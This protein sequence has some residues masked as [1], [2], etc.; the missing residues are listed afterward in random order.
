MAGHNIIFILIGIFLAYRIF[1][2]VQR[3]FGWQQLSL[4]RLRIVN[5]LFCLIGLLFIIEGAFHW[6]S[7]V[8]DVIGAILG[9]I[10]AYYSAASTRFEVRESHLLYCSSI[11]ISGTVTLIFI[12]RLLYRIYQV[13]QDI[14]AHQFSSQWSSLAGTWTSGLMLIMIAYYF[15]FNIFLMRKQKRLQTV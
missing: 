14:S 9:I 3:T 10:L 13:M 2:R 11:W 8:S 5:I 4:R 1:K 7:L 6:V 12:G 15:T